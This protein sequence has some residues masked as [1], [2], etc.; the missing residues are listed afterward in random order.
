MQLSKVC[1]CIVF[2]SNIC[3]LICAGN[4]TMDYSTTVVV[5]GIPDLDNRYL[6]NVQRNDKHT[7]RSPSLC[8]RSHDDTRTIETFADLCKNINFFHLLSFKT[9]I[10]TVFMC[11]II[12][13]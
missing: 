7:R 4:R 6:L 13:L 10:M 8:L 9:M 2:F 3:P 12:D 1:L 11:F 5:N